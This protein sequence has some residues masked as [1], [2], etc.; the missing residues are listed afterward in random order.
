MQNGK[1]NDTNYLVAMFNIFK[2]K[3]YNF[4]FR[5]PDFNFRVTNVYIW[6][7]IWVYIAPEILVSALW[8]YRQI[9]KA[10]KSEVA[11]VFLEIWTCRVL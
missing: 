4:F 1:A 7:L 5:S 6:Y 10:I 11:N 8:V 3:I 2:A 9:T